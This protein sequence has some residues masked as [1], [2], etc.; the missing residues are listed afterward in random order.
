MH[1]SIATACAEVTVNVGDMKLTN[2]GR[3]VMSDCRMI[4]PVEFTN[5]MK[6]HGSHLTL[7]VENVILTV[8]MLSDV[9]E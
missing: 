3:I 4:L 7:L 9:F 6:S 8:N 2:S 5:A 1:V